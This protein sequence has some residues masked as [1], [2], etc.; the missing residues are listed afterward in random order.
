MDLCSQIFQN[1]YN[2]NIK[3]NH[4]NSILKFIV[5]QNYCTFNNK[6][7]KIEDGLPMG[8]PLSGILADIF[9]NYIETSFIV[10]SNNK[11]NPNI[12]KW[13]RYVDD[14]FCIWRGNIDTL[15]EFYKFLNTIHSNLK[16]TMEIERN[17]SL[18]FLDLSIHNSN[19]LPIFNIYRKPSS[20][21]TVIPF[22]SYHPLSI[23]LAA[24]RFYI[25]RT[26]TYPLT[27]ENKIEEFKFIFNLAK[28][29]NFPNKYIYSII[30]RIL[31]KIDPLYTSNTTDNFIYKSIPF[32][33]LST[34]VKPI[35]NKY[36]IHPMYTSKH[37]LLTLLGNYKNSNFDLLSE[38]GVY[39]IG[40]LDC[41]ASY[42][43]Q[44][45]R[46][47]AKRISEHK[48][49]L[50][51][52]IFRHKLDTGHRIDYDNPVFIYR[53]QKG[54]KLDL[55]ERFEIEKHKYSENHILLNDQIEF[56][57]TPL[58]KYTKFNSF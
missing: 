45:G 37:N 5:S 23:K 6:F 47:L 10:N 38:S 13:L 32:N 22:D 55:L 43:G 11:F 53:C 33:R 42:I 26:I 9:M 14:I 57:D 24:F 3:I 20:I 12:V 15:Y 58:F 49:Q 28:E 16:F 7:Y 51:S 27:F 8:F 48:R 21:V 30:Y 50:S 1:F 2:D 4:L 34:S 17:K 41:N 25:H 40:C 19:N 54:Y 56:S 35:L 52:N 46:A 36:N 31:M 44:T 18:N 29:N 39:S